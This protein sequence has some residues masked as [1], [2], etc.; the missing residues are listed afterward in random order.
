M[1]GNNDEVEKQSLLEDNNGRAIDPVVR[2]GTADPTVAAFEREKQRSSRGHTR[3]IT[4]GT[5]RFV[6]PPFPVAPGML[7]KSY[8]IS[9]DG[10]P[11][12]LTPVELGRQELYT[13]VPFTAVFGLQAREREVRQAFA[14]YAAKINVQSHPEWDE[15]EK[16]KMSSKASAMILDE[17][18]KVDSTD[19]LTASFLLAVIVATASQ[20][21]VGYNTGVMNAPEK[22]VFP[23]HSTG[24]WSLVSIEN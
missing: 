7:P 19:R 17:L 6:E 3:A 1:S 5:F 13:Q 20:F 22:V 23:G 11:S 18:D 21:S 9:G 8:S 15:K 2:Y 24:L 10:K 4:M 14:S 16:K 12:Y